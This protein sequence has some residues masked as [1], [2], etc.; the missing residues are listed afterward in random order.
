MYIARVIFLCGSRNRRLIEYLLDDPYGLISCSSW[1]VNNTV[2]FFILKFR[3]HSL[4]LAR[5]SVFLI[6]KV[7]SQ[8]LKRSKFM[9]KPKMPMKI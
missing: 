7:N 4:S 3:A 6:K 9:K 1:M 2:S 8:N 5:E